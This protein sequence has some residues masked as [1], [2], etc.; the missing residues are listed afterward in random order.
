MIFHRKRRQIDINNLSLNN[1]VLQRVNYTKFWVSLSMMV[2]NGLIII[3]YVKNKIAKG[4]G[5]ILRAHKFFNRKTLLTVYHAF[6]FPYVIYCV[7]IWGNA[8]DIHLIPII[9]LQKKIV[10]AITLSRYLTHPVEIFDILTF[11]FIFSYYFVLLV[12]KARNDCKMGC[13][14]F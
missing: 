5:I 4:F 2:L 13:L 11:I 6:I 10:R 12:S 14:H 3:A 1:T 7:E 9:I 8:R